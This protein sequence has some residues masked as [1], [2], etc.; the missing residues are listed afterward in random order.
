MILVRILLRLFTGV[1]LDTAVFDFT[2]VDVLAT[3]M[4]SGSELESWSSKRARRFLFKGAISL[5]ISFWFSANIFAKSL[6]IS[7]SQ[8]RFDIV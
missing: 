8:S 5:S 7:F 2:G 4:F 1:V 6:M 3:E